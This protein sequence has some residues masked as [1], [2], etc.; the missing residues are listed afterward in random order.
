MF[1]ERLAAETVSMQGTEDEAT[2]VPVTAA[3]QTVLLSVQRHGEQGT[4]EGEREIAARRLSLDEA[5]DSLVGI[6]RSVGQRLQETGSTKAT[7]EFGC[8]FAVESGQLVAVLGKATARSTFKV[9]LE[10]AAPTP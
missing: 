4:P 2:L 3:G 9:A 6:A 8:E 1:D 7:V 10:W 5:V